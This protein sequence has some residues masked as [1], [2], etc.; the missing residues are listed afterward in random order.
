MTGYSN[1][2]AL[3]EVTSDGEGNIWAI[4]GN[5]DFVKL[6][7]SNQSIGDSP[8]SDKAKIK[9]WPNPTNGYL[10]TNQLLDNVKV[11]IYDVNQK[12]IDL[13][14]T[15]KYFSQLDLSHLQNG[16]YFIKFKTTTFIEVHKVIIN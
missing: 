5:Y 10:N 9:L 3:E 15:S 16:I 7:P 8:R 2:G 4:S 12:L 11:E 14:S 6:S 13:P 1:F